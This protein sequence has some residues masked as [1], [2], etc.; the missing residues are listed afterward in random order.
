MFCETSAGELNSQNR[1]HDVCKSTL[2]KVFMCID[3][4]TDTLSSDNSI[5]PNVNIYLSVLSDSVIV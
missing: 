3:T 4:R 1:Q 5:R 2:Y